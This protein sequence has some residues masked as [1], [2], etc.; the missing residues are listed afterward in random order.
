MGQ[1]SQPPPSAG[2]RSSRPSALTG[3]HSASKS[4]N[5]ADQ[6]Q[7]MSMLSPYQPGAGWA[8]MMNTP[9]VPT[10]AA[11][12]SSGMGMG[13]VAAATQNK[14]NALST[15]NNRMQL[16]AAPKYRRAHSTEGDRGQPQQPGFGMGGGVLRDPAGHPLSPEQAA[17]IQQQQLMAMGA[18]RSPTGSPVRGPIGGPMGNMNFPQQTNGFLSVFGSGPSHINNGMAAMNLNPYGGAGDG[19]YLSDASDI[20]RGR[21]PR[22]RRG[23]SRPP[24]DPTDP[25]LLKDVPSWLRTLRLHKYTDNLKDM[26]WTDIVALDDAGLEAKGVSAKGARTKML[27]VCHLSRLDSRV[28]SDC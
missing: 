27:K 16:D 5:Q 22:G 9:M 13:D 1:F 7:A 2:L 15:I 28:G 18:G 14:L 6:L 8:S 21:S 20:N 24:D 25:E 17:M 10:F 3:D 23:T 4:M 11:Q 26:K 12:Q 19:G